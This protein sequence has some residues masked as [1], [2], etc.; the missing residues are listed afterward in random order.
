MPAETQSS[1]KAL[2]A[3]WT[4]LNLTAEEWLAVQCQGYVSS[5]PR[6]QRGCVYYL[7][8]RVHGRQK[9]RYLGSDPERAKAVQ[10]AI[11]AQRRPRR[12]LARLRRRLREVRTY[13]A[14]MKPQLEPYALAAGFHFHGRAIRRRKKQP[15]P[16]RLNQ[17][18]VD[19]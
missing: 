13:L 5:K 11:E 6:G 14:S 2:E 10:A 15:P 12:A 19:V 8:F 18:A 16:P 17:S 1:P 4:A 7:R 3:P 9:A